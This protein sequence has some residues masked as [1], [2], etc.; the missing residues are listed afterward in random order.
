MKLQ[1][2]TLMILT[3]IISMYWGFVHAVTAINDS[4]IGRIINVEGEV[5]LKRQNWSDYGPV[6][7]GTEL[8]AEDKIKLS[9]EAY[10]MAVCYANWKTWNFPKNRISQVIEGCLPIKSQ[11]VET[12]DG[13]VP[14]DVTRSSTPV[15]IAD[16]IPYV[17]SPR[18]TL[19]FPHQSFILR[20]NA[21]ADATHYRVII[22]SPSEYIWETEVSE[23][24]VI[25]SG[26]VPLKPGV[27]YT[28]IIHSDTGTSSLDEISAF[29]KQDVL[30]NGFMVISPRQ[31]K[32]IVAKTQRLNQQLKGEAKRLA[33]AA[34]YQ[35]NGLKTEAITVLESWL[36]QGHHTAAVYQILGELYQ[37]IQLPFLA[38]DYYLK[39]IEL[40]A[41]DNQAGNAA[42]EAALGN[43]YLTLGNLEEAAYWLNVASNRYEALGEFQRGQELKQL[44]E[45]L[46]P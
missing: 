4:P 1:R 12:P 32:Q 31:Q 7:I 13:C 26:E 21:V 27:R 5:F 18:H 22:K 6:F 33:L 40:M 45:R 11:C 15:L 38:K 24:Q 42:I 44:I 20:W 41:T 30:G 23:N 10:L 3:I 2:M 17:I 9:S 25:Y 36:Q 29:S 14:F 46:N 8:E 16:N 37:Q 34:F 35:Q 28:V 43:I 39:S 19:L